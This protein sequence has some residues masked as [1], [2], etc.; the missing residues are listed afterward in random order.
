M[1][2][3][4]FSKTYFSNFLTLLSGN[5]LS[6][7]F[8]FL[9]APVLSR[10]FAPTDFA[11]FA[12]FM[13]IVSMLGIVASGRLEL[14]IPIPAEKDKAQ[15]IAH[16][17]LLITVVIGALSLMIPLFS[18]D[19]SRFYGDEA[20]SAYL[21]LVPLSVVSYGILGIANNWNLRIEKYKTISLGK[22][23]QSIVNN[24]GAA[25]LGYLSFGVKGLI[26]GWLLSQYANIFVLILNLKRKH[27][28]SD[29]GLQS[30]KTT[31]KE[32]KDFPLINSLHAFTDI[33]VS[34]FL[35]F[36]A[37][38]SYFGLPELGFFAVM[39]KYVR[40]PISLISSSVSQL[41]FVEAT[42][43]LNKGENIMPI[44]LKTVKTS[45]FFG[46]PF[47][48]VLLL[49]GPVLFQWYLGDVWI[50]SGIYAQYMTPVFL[51][52]F[53]TSPISILPIIMKEQKRS[54]LLSFLG[55]SISLVAL[56]LGVSFGYDFKIA[57]LMYS[58]T[59]C[60]Y[61]VVNL[62]WFRSLIVKKNESYH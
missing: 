40:A 11:I 60:L 52:M 9:F 49:F 58:L 21:W 7:L 5:T 15:N 14:A 12:N 39:H 61:Y 47:L 34:Q 35:L 30:A 37:I 6:Q 62:I 18:S 44:A 19:V 22:V 46:V 25:L 50:E 53:M 32:Y 57:L 36:W 31:L 1:E 8:P 2:N 20:L 42:K 3:K 10:I 16:T 24:G 27:E 23:V 55:Y 54:F 43:A 29:L 13:A 41:F 51:F 45:L 4:E 28:R 56:F 33:F 17:G 59:F 26:V 38:S 48:V